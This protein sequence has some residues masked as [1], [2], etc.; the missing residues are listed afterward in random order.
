M[1]AR[2]PDLRESPSGHSGQPPYIAACELPGQRSAPCA[3]SQRPAQGGFASP[4]FPRS[5]LRLRIQR[6]G[7]CARLTRPRL[8]FRRRTGRRAG[9]CS[10]ERRQ[11]VVE[12]AVV[13]PLLNHAVIE[14]ELR[15]GEISGETDWLWVRLL[16]V[17]RALTARRW[18]ADGELVLEAWGISSWAST[19]ATCS[20]SGTAKPSAS[21]PTG[22]PTWPWTSATWLDLPRLHHPQPARACRAHPRA[23]P[24]RQRLRR[25]PLPRRAPPHRLHW[26]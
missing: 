3:L 4:C 16:D 13:R 8:W 5:T 11:W 9:V 15:A 18:I 23:P 22:H 6:R 20:P 17:S 10:G 14:V 21:R 24:R 25:R 7:G 2:G 1:S 19:A 26:F 12:Q